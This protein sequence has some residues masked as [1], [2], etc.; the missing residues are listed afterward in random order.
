[1]RYQR[2]SFMP[3]RGTIN[4]IR[5]LVIENDPGPDDT[6]T[7]MLESAGEIGLT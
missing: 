1:M 6:S 2:Y 3:E 4:V 7:E 5:K